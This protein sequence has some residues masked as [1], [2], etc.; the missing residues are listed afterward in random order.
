MKHWIL[1]GSLVAAG[2]LGG[3]LYYYFIGCANRTCAIQSNPLIATIYGGLI[4]LLLAISTSW[5]QQKPKEKTE[6]ADV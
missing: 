3:Y 1:K 6:D 5:F 2:M 4:G